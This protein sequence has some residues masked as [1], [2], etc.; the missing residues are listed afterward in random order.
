MT[1][2]DAGRPIGEV[3]DRLTLAV[4]LA[5]FNR[6]DTTLRCLA[7]LFAQQTDTLRLSVHLL[8][9]ASTDGTAEAVRREFPDVEVIA[10]NGALFWGG[11]MCAAMRAATA[12]PF[13]ALLL[14]ND[15]VA[16]A[17]DSLSILLEAWRIADAGSS[18]PNIIVGATTDPS[19]LAISYSGFRRT[20]KVN[21]FRLR[22]MPPVP[23]R[24]VPCDTMNGNCV[25]IPVEIVRRIGIIDPVFIHQLGDLDYGYRAIKAGGALWIAPQPIG[26]CAAN[27]RPRRWARPGIGA[28]ARWKL[29]DSPL[30]LPMR[31]WLA[32]GWRHAGVLGIAIVAAIYGKILLRDFIGLPIGSNQKSSA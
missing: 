24:L 25:L 18:G 6:R 19:T 3:A 16:L 31:P 15:D 4:A 20:S 5:C 8:D 12:H 22:R 23:T 7:S 21:P 17:P 2:S 29:L 32:F 13:D 10:G 30:G 14:L 1:L 28:V 26:T 27:D 11:G 9:D